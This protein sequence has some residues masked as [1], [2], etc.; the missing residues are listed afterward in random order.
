MRKDPK[1]GRKI[2]LGAAVAGIGGYLAGV[3]T[4]PKSGKDTRDDLQ[5]KVND[6]KSDAAEQLQA[7]QAELGDT[8]KKAQAKTVALSSQARDEFN[9]AVI[10]AKDAQNKAKMVLKALKAGEAD[11]PELNKAVKQARQAQKNLSKFLKS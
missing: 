9:E 11:D 10:R 3:L 6:F 1:T 7:A 8:L 4:A 5:A 2:A